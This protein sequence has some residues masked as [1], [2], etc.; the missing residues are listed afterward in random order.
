MTGRRKFLFERCLGRGGFGEVYLA[1]M[2][3][4]SGLH[5]TVAVKT[6]HARLHNN[7]DAVSRLRDEARLLGALHHRGIVQI[8]D[9]V[10]V[11]GQMALVT[12]Y[13]DGQDLDR[14]LKDVGALPPRVAVEVIGE[15]A[16]AL[17]AAYTTI[18]PGT[19][20]PMELVHRDIK[21]SNVRLLTNGGVKLLDFGIARSPNVSREAKTGTGL[22][23]GTMGYLSPDRLTDESLDPS[24]DIYGLGC[25]LYEALRCQ[26]L[27]N[28][29]RKAELFRLALDEEKHDE[30]IQ[31]R[32]DDSPEGAEPLAP[33]VR[34]LLERLLSYLP[35]A[36]PTAAELEECCDELASSLPSPHLRRWARARS[37]PEATTFEPGELDG[38]EL[39]ASGMIDTLAPPTGATG[40]TGATSAYEDLSA[41]V[42][43]IDP[44]ATP[45]RTRSSGPALM[46]S[47][48]AGVVV[49]GVGG[50]AATTLLPPPPPAPPTVNAQ[51]VGSPAAAP[52]Q[53]AVEE[54]DK[55]REPAAEAG[56]GGAP[57]PDG[58]PAD[59]APAPVA[60]DPPT[61]AL[62]E[63]P[64]KPAPK[65]TA[66]AESKA[67]P[68][69]VQFNSIPYSTEIVIDGSQTVRAKEPV[70]LAP[71]NH[72]VQLRAADGRS[73]THSFTVHSG[74]KAVVCWDFGSNAPCD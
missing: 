61:K 50:Y 54:Q 8:Y 19:D 34:T 37:W 3:T 72:S 63:G 6:L 30:F 33:E 49:L 29:V 15:V 48:A 16:A 67:E 14:V 58:G 36:R 69:I 23:I 20:R 53:A 31:S 18:S 47:I 62:D 35:D 32:L 59:P 10:E 4:S 68:G 17:H 42:A 44:P 55:S 46:A 57:S 22:V 56:D 70:M 7:S 11:H 43:P 65:A 1:H 74:G 66:P 38:M 40:A 5:R 39:S 25:V 26:R 60:K 41:A 21:P 71:G 28:N 52:D 13:L 45:Q 24:S 51:P 2:V 27:Y 12:E 73:K 64:A 9:L